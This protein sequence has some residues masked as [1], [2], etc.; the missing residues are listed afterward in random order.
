MSRRVARPLWRIQFDLKWLPSSNLGTCLKGEEIILSTLRIIKSRECKAVRFFSW[1]RFALINNRI[2][3]RVKREILHQRSKGLLLGLY[4]VKIW[5]S[6]WSLIHIS[7]V[8][9][10]IGS[11]A[12]ITRDGIGCN[13]QSGLTLMP[14]LWQVDGVLSEEQYFHTGCR[15][16]LKYLIAHGPGVKYLFP[17]QIQLLSD[18]PLCPQTPQFSLPVKMSKKHSL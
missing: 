3:Y 13:V 1:G 4:F 2:K 10:R 6:I 9:K 5:V 18:I 14:S 15:S 16:Q 17:H 8:S 12:D 11:S 7:E